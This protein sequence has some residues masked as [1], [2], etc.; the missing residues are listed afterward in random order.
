MKMKK[1]VL[2]SI[3]L[4]CIAAWTFTSCNVNAPSEDKLFL[5]EDQVTELTKDGKVYN[6]ND[7]KEKFLSDTGNYCAQNLYRTRGTVQGVDWLLF[8]LDTLPKDG[9]GIY[10]RGRIST[11]DYGGNFYKSFIIQQIVGGEQQNLRISIDMGSA[12]GLYQMGQEVI[13]RC[14]GLCLGRYANQAQLCIPTY[15]NNMYAQNAEQKV[16]WAPG[17]ISGPLFRKACHLIGKP[18]Q[19]KLQCDVI[20]ITDF[21]TLT[22]TDK[23]SLKDYC[24]YK[25]ARLVVLENVHCDGKY[26]YRKFWRIVG[27]TVVLDSAQIF[28][29]RYADE[30]GALSYCTDGNPSEDQNA[31]V[32]APTTKN[33]GFP[34][35]RI[36]TDGTNYANI[37]NSEYAKYAFFY[38]PADTMVGSI[39]GILSYY[40]DNGG[41]LTSY[42]AGLPYKWAITPRGLRLAGDIAPGINDILWDTKWDP[43][44]YGGLKDTIQ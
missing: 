5:S 44:E 14:N 21:N 35:S 4:A 43:T 7:F 26:D 13:I 29:G 1:T 32:F 3:A 25:D 18:D 15:N 16:G 20:K 42:K 24:I 30:K 8:S 19:S 28:L 34:Q 23:A 31:R 6:L 33:V 12:N 37:S 9:E 2:Y 27:D 39:R 36:I 38:L 40:A 41:K 22:G 11:D 10:I 17:R